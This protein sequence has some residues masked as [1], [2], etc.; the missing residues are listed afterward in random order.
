[1]FLWQIPHSKEFATKLLLHV[2]GVQ[3]IYEFP[4]SQDA[5]ISSTSS[6]K[7]VGFCH[8]ADCGKNNNLKF[9]SVTVGVGPLDRTILVLL[10]FVMWFDQ[11]SSLKGKEKRKW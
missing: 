1:M 8:N 9:Q 5:I 4:P 2:C 10:R 11:C 7:I 6:F 3:F